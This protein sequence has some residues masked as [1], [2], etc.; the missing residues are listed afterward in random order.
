[1]RT[2]FIVVTTTLYFPNAA[3][4]RDRR[5]VLTFKI[6]LIPLRSVALLRIQR[7]KEESG[8]PTRYI[9]IY[10]YVYAR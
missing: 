9:Y 6:K 2:S 3:V 8:V 5:P 10:I 7:I 4:F 1:M